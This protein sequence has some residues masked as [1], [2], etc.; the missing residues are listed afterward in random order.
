MSILKGAEKT[1]KKCFG[2]EVEV[3]FCAMYQNQPL[4]G[5]V[6]SFL[7]SHGF[8]IFGLQRTTWKR[9]ECI[10]EGQLICGN[11]LYLESL[12]SLMV[13]LNTIKGEE[14]KVAKTLKAVSICLLYKRYDFAM[15]IVETMRN[16][17]TSQQMDRFFLIFRQLKPDRL[18]NN[19]RDKVLLK[20]RKL[21]HKIER[22][23]NSVTG[24][25]RW[26]IGDKE[27]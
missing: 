13:M 8:Q 4:F 26:R 11:A 21:N 14:L 24:D 17:F 16:L 19:L 2:L 10:G 9:N 7:R 22:L 12:D 18:P 3:E 5:E 15:E 1:L 6:D 23:I 27:L 20:T 25:Y